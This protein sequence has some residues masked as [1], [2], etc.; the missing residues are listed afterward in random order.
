MDDG[1]GQIEVTEGYRCGVDAED[2]I[3]LVGECVGGGGCQCQWDMV[4]FAED[5]PNDYE[6]D[7]PEE[8]SLIE[9]D[10]EL[11]GIDEGDN[12]TDVPQVEEQICFD[13]GESEFCVLVIL[14]LLSHLH[15]FI[16]K[17]PIYLLWF[18]IS[19]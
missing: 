11:I 4:E 3:P 17:H 9:V 13:F 5:E 8:T 10:V 15:I 2:D 12:P 6:I 16:Y 19:G 14:R 18:T 7:A 1:N